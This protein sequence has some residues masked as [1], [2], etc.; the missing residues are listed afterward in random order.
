MIERLPAEFHRRQADRTPPPPQRFSLMGWLTG[1]F[2]EIISICAL[3][4]ICATLVL[5]AVILFASDKINLVLAPCM[6]VISAALTA[7][8][9][10]KR[11]N[12]DKEKKN[13]N[14]NKAANVLGDDP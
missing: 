9:G 10:A 8:V 12:K 14:K 1:Y 5:L 11:K 3:A 4:I 6:S 13:K 2:D 7:V